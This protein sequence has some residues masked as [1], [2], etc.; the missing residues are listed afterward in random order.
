[1]SIYERAKER[2][3]TAPKWKKDLT[4]ELLKSKRKTFQRRRIFSPDVDHIWTMDLLDI[5]RFSRQNTNFRFILVVLDV[6]SRFAWARPLKDKTAKSVANSLQDIITTSG[7]K[8]KK[9]WS[10]KGTEFYNST[11]NSL[12]QRNNIELYSTHNEP[13]ASIAERFIRTLRGKIESNFILTQSTVWYDILPELMREYNNSCHRSVGMTPSEAIRKENHVK[14][15]NHLYPRRDMKEKDRLKIGDKVRI[16][17]HKTLFEKGAT[18]NWSE[19]IFEIT[20]LLPTQPIV[21]CIKDLADEPVIGTFYREQLQKTNQNVYRIDRVVR[22][23]GDEVLVKW[24]GYPDKFN[25]WIP[26][27]DVLQSG[28]ELSQFE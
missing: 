26:K 27:T 17:V 20:N 12:L 2:R 6:F 15:F 9:I 28:G 7:R 13:K 24:S 1:M 3:T 8:P 18:A 22:K 19:E 11:V 21:Y 23:R 25:S 4:T 10:D 5:H 16:S 14:V